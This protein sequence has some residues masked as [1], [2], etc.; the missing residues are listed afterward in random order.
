[1]IQTLQTNITILAVLHFTRS[2]SIASNAVELPLLTVLFLTYLGQVDYPWVHELSEKIE[3]I[4]HNEYH[5][6][7]SNENCRVDLTDLGIHILRFG[8]IGQ[9]DNQHH[10]DQGIK[11][12]NTGQIIVP[13]SIHQ[14]ERRTLPIIE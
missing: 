9:I 13:I 14:Q 7:E 5:N 8:G 12:E 6:V 3:N 11:Y 1:M 2:I 4:N 10:N